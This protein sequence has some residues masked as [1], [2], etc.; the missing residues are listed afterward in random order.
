MNG[1]ISIPYKFVE[2]AEGLSTRAILSVGVTVVIFSI[3]WGVGYAV[4]TS[5]WG[6]AFTLSALLVAC[7]TLLLTVAAISQYLGFERLI[8]DEIA[9]RSGNYR[10]HPGHFGL[11]DMAV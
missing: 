4:P 6:D 11:Q 9:A 2:I 8:D 1:T 3:C 10:Y 7:F 5:E